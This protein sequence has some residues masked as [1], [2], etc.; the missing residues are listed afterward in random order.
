MVEVRIIREAENP[1]FKRREIVFEVLHPGGQIPSLFQVREM[2]S[3]LKGVPL[4]NIYVLSLMGVSGMQSSRGEAHVYYSPEH[5]GI[6]PL[7]VK[8]AN[9]PPQEKRQRKEELRKMKME[10]KAKARSGGK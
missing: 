1:L 4:E 7:H 8:I 9:L 2:I 5:A 3:S 6:E 10:A